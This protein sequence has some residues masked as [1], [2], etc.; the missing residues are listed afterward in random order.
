MTK[1][2]EIASPLDVSSVFHF[3]ALFPISF[4]IIHL[5][6]SKKA[7]GQRNWLRDDEEDDDL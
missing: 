6:L 3:F 4:S 1:L 2:L 5:L 7:A